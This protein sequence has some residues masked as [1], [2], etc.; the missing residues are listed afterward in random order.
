MDEVAFE[1]SLLIRIDALNGS[2]LRA[3]LNITLRATRLASRE[4]NGE[5]LLIVLR[6]N[7]VVETFST[8]GLSSPASACPSV[9]VDLLVLAV[10]HSPH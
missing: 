5:T 8:V 2:S 1:S 6:I 9:N 7:G 3:I 10:A 4:A